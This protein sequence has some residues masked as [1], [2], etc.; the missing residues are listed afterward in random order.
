MSDTRRTRRDFERVISATSNG[1]SPDKR[2]RRRQHRR[3]AR[4]LMLGGTL[5][6]GKAPPGS[7]PHSAAQWHLLMA[8]TWKR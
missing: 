6:N 2:R 1:F 3:A 8:R 5:L 7:I 4:A